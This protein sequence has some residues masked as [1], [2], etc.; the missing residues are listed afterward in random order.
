LG[1]SSTTHF[2]CLF[3]QLG[4]KNGAKWVGTM[5]GKGGIG[6]NASF[7]LCGGLL[8]HQE[9]WENYGGPKIISLKLPFLSGIEMGQNFRGKRK[10]NCRKIGFFTFTTK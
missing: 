6:K 7:C 4:T 10:Q 5:G 9:R 2:P 1:Y 3:R 8:G